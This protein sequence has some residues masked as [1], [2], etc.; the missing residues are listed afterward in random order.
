MQNEGGKKDR[1]PDRHASNRRIGYEA[2][3]DSKV[4]AMR[5]SSIG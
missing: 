1:S 2:P 4:K 3:H 5:P